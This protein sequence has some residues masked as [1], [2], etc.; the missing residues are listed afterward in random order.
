MFFS[1]CR[2]EWIIS[3]SSLAIYHSV[4]KHWRVSVLLDQASQIAETH[5]EVQD[6]ESGLQHALLSF[7][8]RSCLH[9]LSIIAAGSH[10]IKRH[11][12]PFC[13][14]DKLSN[15]SGFFHLKAWPAWFLIF[16]VFNRLAHSDC[17][18]LFFYVS[19][20]NKQMGLCVVFKA[21]S[22]FP[23][24]HSAEA[25]GLRFSLTCRGFILFPQTTLERL[26]YKLWGQ[27]NGAESQQ[28]LREFYSNCNTAFKFVASLRPQQQQELLALKHQQELL[29]HQRK[30]ENHRME[31]ELEKQQREQKL[32]LLKNK[33]RGQESKYKSHCS[34]RF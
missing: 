5:W 29:E 30:M 28:P 15:H 32:Q 21:S 22:P 14:Q 20:E 8:W 23:P 18:F 2:P 10:R 24:K 34:A 13:L 25:Y 4:K 26:E 7:N 16:K 33:E 11:F 6:G 12:W 27:Q 9:S 1:A 19:A 31:Q 3:L 17:H